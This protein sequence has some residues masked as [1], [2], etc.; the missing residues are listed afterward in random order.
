MRLRNDKNAQYILDSYEYTAKTFPIVL[1]N[2]DVVEIGAGKGEMITQLAKLNP[3]TTYYA[4][5][6][7]PTVAAKIVKKAKEL[8]LNNLI[9]V[10]KDAKDLSELFTGQCDTLWLTFSDPWPK[11]RHEKR[12][13]TYK[14]FLNQYKDILT[15]QGLL[16]FKSDND[17]LFEYSLES[18]QNNNWIIINQTND[19]HNS[20]FNQN[21]IP[22]GYE[23]KWSSLGKNINYLEAKHK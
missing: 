7:Y 5:E 19:L 14:T 18:L 4:F 2:T 1:K 8:Q 15:N 17:K 11:V 20:E 12:R 10:C 9:I 21:N 22:T 13:L 3:Q 23:I 6:K 16:K